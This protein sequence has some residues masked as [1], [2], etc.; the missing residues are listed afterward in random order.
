MS[1]PMVIYKDFQINKNYPGYEYLPAL[2]EAGGVYHEDREIDGVLYRATNATFN[3]I[4]GNWSQFNGAKAAYA[5]TQNADGTIGYLYMPPQGAGTWTAWQSTDV[6]EFYAINYGLDPSDMTGATN[7]PA[8]QDAVYAALNNGGGIIR[9]PAGTYQ[10]L[11]NI[12]IDFSAYPDAGGLIIAGFSSGT[13]LVQNTVTDDIFTVKDANGA[14]GVVIKDMNLEYAKGTPGTVGTQA[15][16]N[17]TSCQNTYCERITFTNC[18]M[19]FYTDGG[20][21]Q[22]GL[23]ECFITYDL[24]TGGDTPSPVGSQTMVSLNGSCDFVTGCIIKQESISSTPAGPSNCIGI[25]IAGGGASR[26]ITDTHISD[27]E[28]GLTITSNAN[29]CYCS[30]VRFDAYGTAVVI[31]P[32]TDTGFV[33]DVHFTGCTF[34]CT[35]YTAGKTSG[36]TI[37]TLGGPAINVSGIYFANCSAYG[38]GNSGI[39]IDSGQNIVITGGQYSSNGQ[40]PSP[41]EPYNNAGIA[42]LGGEDITISGVDCS[43]VNGFWETQS[44]APAAIPQPVGILIAGAV[45]DVLVVGCNLT[46][47]SEYGLS[48]LQLSESTPQKAYIRDCDATGY[49]SWN[50]AMSIASTG[51]L[52]QITNCAGYNDQSVELIAAPP[53]GPPSGS[54]ANYTYGYFGP[55]SFY[56]AVNTTVL[57]ITIGTLNTYLKS[58][59][60]YLAPGQVAQVTVSGAKPAFQMIGQ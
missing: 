53:T 33:N 9:L 4:N 35:S 32:K 31:Q 13:R 50:V 28:S 39:E 38:F 59:A 25:A 36:V 2:P 49:S 51:T 20:C 8:L 48:V 1:A 45:A 26:F 15:A 23:F 52:I 54:F 5:F 40:E 7:T 24:R 42:V 3:D 10:L 34:A 58:G 22:C 56:I 46:G 41:T 6:Q 14:W 11:G 60:F 47:N 43:G 12:T 19:S 21:L 57:E 17:L 29:S 55:V 16:V 44:A 18:P 30:D 37:S 27:F